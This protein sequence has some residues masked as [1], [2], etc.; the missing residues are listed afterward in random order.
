MIRQSVFALFISLSISFSAAAQ[1]AKLVEQAKK[2]GGKLIVY[3]SLE[4]LRSSPLPKLFKR[5]PASRWNTGALPR[6]R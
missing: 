6:P 5:R 4:S 1:D 2:E 3:G